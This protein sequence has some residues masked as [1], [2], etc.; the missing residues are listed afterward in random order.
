MPNRL[1]VGAVYTT[2]LATQRNFDANGLLVQ[3]VLRY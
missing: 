3:M 2:P 1:E